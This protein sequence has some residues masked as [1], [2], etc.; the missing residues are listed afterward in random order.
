[1]LLTPRKWIYAAT[2]LGNA[3]LVLLIH[4]ASAE[5]GKETGTAIATDVK[6]GVKTD[7]KEIRCRHASAV[8]PTVSDSDF[9]AKKN[10]ALKRGIHNLKNFSSFL[11][12][13]YIGSFDD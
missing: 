6:T 4:I 10:P 12:C 13:F 2:I 7:A 9:K 11:Y 5:S 3:T 1:M 8:I